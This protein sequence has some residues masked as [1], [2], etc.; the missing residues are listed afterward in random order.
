M[1]KITLFLLGT[2]VVTIFLGLLRILEPGGTVVGLLVG[3][4]GGLAFFVTGPM[5]LAKK[6]YAGIAKQSAEQ[7]SSQPTKELNLLTDSEVV[8]LV[9]DAVN[10]L[11]QIANHPWLAQHWHKMS[12]A[13]KC[14]WIADRRNKINVEL[15]QARMPMEFVSAL[16]RAETAQT[17]KVS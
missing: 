5:W 4:C 2:C 14:K 6:M 13:D 3:G 9:D 7:Y 12:A 11:P 1:G 15:K 10:K 8:N 17:Q 16:Q